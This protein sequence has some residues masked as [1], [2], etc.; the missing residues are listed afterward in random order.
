MKDVKNYKQYFK[1]WEQSFRHRLAFWPPNAQREIDIKG[2]MFYPEIKNK[3]F[4]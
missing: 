3:I 4:D 1:T 2:G